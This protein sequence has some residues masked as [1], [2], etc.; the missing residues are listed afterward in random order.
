MNKIFILPKDDLNGGLYRRIYLLVRKNR[1]TWQSIGTTFG[2]ACG[3]LS[4]LLGLPLWAGAR[5]LAPS[6][7]GSLLN[8]LSTVLLVLPIPLL[9]VGAYCLDLLEKKPPAIPLP[10]ESRPSVPVRWPRL[11]PQRPHH[12]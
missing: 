6:S 2:L 10:V 12:N 8:V 5:F 3:S 1:W 9:A 7:F 4:I 11:R